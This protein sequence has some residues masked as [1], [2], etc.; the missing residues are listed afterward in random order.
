[1]PIKVCKILTVSLLYFSW[2]YR[3]RSG[4]DCMRASFPYSRTNV[5]DAKAMRI[6]VI[7]AL[8]FLWFFHEEKKERIV[9]ILVPALSVT[10]WKKKKTQKNFLYM[11]RRRDCARWHL[12]SHAEL[13]FCKTRLHDVS[14]T[15]IQSPKHF[16]TEISM[17]NRVT[18]L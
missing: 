17:R 3:I 5:A 7:S 1:M 11:P 8:L 13:S 14:R 16:M 2:E 12:S 4:V 9:W 10:S 15:Q 6:S 18:F